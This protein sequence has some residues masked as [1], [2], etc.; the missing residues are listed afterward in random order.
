MRISALQ[1]GEREVMRLN[2]EGMDKIATVLR[3]E[4]SSIFDGDGFRTVVFLKGCPLRC[5]WCS[6]PESQNFEIEKAEEKLYGKK[7]SVEQILKEVRKD[8]LFYFHSGGGLTVSGGEVLSQPEFSRCLL[9]QARR[10]GINTAIETTFYAKWEIIEKILEHVNTAFVD[11]KFITS[12]LHK[13]YCGV[14][15]ALI[16]ENIKKAD[17]CKE[18]FRFVIRIPLIPGFNDSDEELTKMGTFCA[19]LKKVAYVQIL[20]YHKLGSDTYRKLGRPY[21]LEELL[22][23]EQ[24]HV[25]RCKEVLRKYVSKVI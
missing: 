9:Q 3:W 5:K 22:P 23:P 13:K 8:S 10:E 21:E 18:K 14:D 2:Y 11:L 25:E 19:Q 1:R 15:N 16:L 20:P 7:M 6:T 4:R 12:E 24:E 17:V